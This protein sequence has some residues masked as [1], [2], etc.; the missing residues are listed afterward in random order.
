MSEEHGEILMGRWDCG[1]CGSKGIRGDAYQCSS[2]GSPRPDDVV[3]YL[4]SDAKV[5]T[6]DA[7]VRAA[8]AGADWQCAY[9][10][11]WMPATVDEC[12]NCPAETEDSERR[13]TTRKYAE[14]NV[15]RST[16]AIRSPSGHEI[17]AGKRQ[18]FA[19]SPQARKRRQPIPWMLFAVL[20]LLGVMFFSCGLIFTVNRHQRWQ[21]EQRRLAERQAFI[22]TRQQEMANAQQAYQAA[23]SD[24]NRAKQK[25]SEAREQVK[26]A[27]ARVRELATTEQ[28]LTQPQAVEVQEHRWQVVLKIQRCE[29]KAGQGWNYPSDAIDIQS[30]QRVHHHERVVDRVDT[31]FRTETY[32]EQDGFDTERYTERVAKGTRQVPDGY[33]VRDLGNGR[34]ERVQKYRTETVYVNETKT[35]RTP[36]M[37]TKTRQIPYQ[38]NVYR[39]EPVK[40]PWFTYRTKHWLPAPDMTRK[41]VGIEP[42]NPADAPSPDSP[43]EVGALRLADRQVHYKLALK[44][45]S[46]AGLGEQIVLSTPRER[47]E[48]FADGSSALLAQGELFSESELQIRLAKVRADM[49]TAKLNV[50]V[51][52]AKVPPLFSKISELDAKLPPLRG[53]LEQTEQ[54]YEAANNND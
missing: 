14:E 48:Q 29:A 33:D 35:R 37:V 46:G 44:P 24:V 1:S 28:A 6:N 47:W 7:A 10:D 13:Q 30:E 11:S 5:L 34:F 4:P 27:E 32:R 26:R 20:A 45:Q 31:L 12:Q 23:V 17:P 42:Q 38:Q 50:N 51:L 25:A 43:A 8:R 16:A 9:C 54:A 22:A 41:G 52:E 3:F 21:A 19:A 2:C 15:P 40:K 36:R 39:E 18:A 53:T 49:E